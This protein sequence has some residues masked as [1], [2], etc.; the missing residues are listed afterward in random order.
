MS[1][2]RIS[3]WLLP[4]PPSSA[5]LNASIQQLSA[6][7]QMSPFPAHLTLLSPWEASRDQ[8]EAGLSDFT[9]DIKALVLNTNGLNHSQAF[10]RAIV[11]ETESSPQLLSLRAALARQISWQLEGIYAP[12]LSLAYG[13]LPESLRIELLR[14]VQFP[15]H[16]RF[17]RIRAIAPGDNSQGREDYAAWEILGEWAL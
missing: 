16:I 13:H 15:S 10:Y 2:R 14:T 8:L 5:R 6:L 4:D 3:F 1:K 9:S 12:H 11:I 17:D 7:V